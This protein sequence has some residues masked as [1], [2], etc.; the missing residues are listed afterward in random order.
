MKRLR[1]ESHQEKSGVVTER[2]DRVEAELVRLTGEPEPKTP[3][4]RKKRKAYLQNLTNFRDNL[5]V[6]SNLAEGQGVTDGKQLGVITQLSLSS[7]GLPVAW[8]SWYGSVPIPEQPNRLKDEPFLQ[9]LKVG[10]TITINENHREAAGKTFEVKEFKGGGWI[11][12]TDNRLF[13]GEFFQSV[14]GESDLERP[15]GEIVSPRLLE[16]SNPSENARSNLAPES[17]PIAHIRRDGG[18]QPRATINQLTVAE[19]AEDM[20]K[21]DRFPPV[22][23]FYDGTDYWLTDG[24]HRV[25]A[26]ESLGAS[27][28]AVDI[29]QGTRRDAILY[30]VGANVRHGLRRTNTDKRRVVMM[31]LEDGEW[32]QYSNNHIAKL[33]CVSLDLVNRSRRSLNDSLSERERIYATK[34]GTVSTMDTTNIGRHRKSLSDTSPRLS[35][36]GILTETTLSESP[37]DGRVKSNLRS[38]TVGSSVTVTGEHPRKGQ[39]GE[40]TVLPN[41]DAAIILF[42][43]GQREIFGLEFLSPPKPTDV[44]VTFQVREGLNYRAGNGCEWYVRVEQ[45][46]WERLRS[47]QTRVGTATLDGAIKRMLEMVS[48]RENTEL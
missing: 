44:P 13:H 35:D 28:I 15:T 45:S 20:T 38:L 30:S 31:L 34:H 12:T 48:I 8:V 7:G 2:L 43:D 33:C 47:Y 9:N 22:L 32:S 36:D 24:F 3:K 42:D 5:Q 17:L 4:A 41:P 40:I 10:D 29:R 21:G 26:A 37:T 27:T 19:Y 23:V 16:R 18:T 39:T 25:L 1:N 11:L 46:T 14:C 6:Y